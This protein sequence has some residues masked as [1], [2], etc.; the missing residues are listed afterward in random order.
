MQKKVTLGTRLE[1]GTGLN[2]KVGYQYVL[3]EE[4]MWMR[5]LSKETHDLMGFARDEDR[6]TKNI[7]SKTGQKYERVEFRVKEHYSFGL[8]FN[9]KGKL[10]GL[11]KLEKLNEEM[12][13][14]VGN[15]SKK[16]RNKDMNSYQLLDEE[17]VKY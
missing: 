17:S 12:W 9:W 5:R 10:N 8:L 4:T 11:E 3:I 1:K 6:K 7:K 2:V 15:Y 14:A 13:E 16:K